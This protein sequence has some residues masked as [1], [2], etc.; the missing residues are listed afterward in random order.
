M[1]NKWLSSGKVTEKEEFKE[2]RK[3]AQ[4]AIREAKNNWF[5]LKA[6]EA[7]KSKRWEGGVKVHPRNP[8]RDKR[9]SASEDKKC[10]GRGGSHLQH[11]S[12]TA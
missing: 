4:K 10:E 12:A 7:Q 9:P 6:K 1:Y 2:A 11:P 5:S 3:K 8:K